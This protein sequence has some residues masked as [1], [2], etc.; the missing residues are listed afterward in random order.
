MA[1]VLAVVGVVASI[2][3]LVKSTKEIIDRLNEYREAAGELPE[4]LSHVYVEL[5]LLS[6]TLQRTGASIEN[7]AIHDTNI[8][9]P[10]IK[11]CQ[12]QIELLQPVLAKLV[13]SKDDSTKEKIRKGFSSIYRES[14][15]SR[16]TT[17]IRHYVQTLT[18]YHTV[19]SALKLGKGEANPI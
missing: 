11:G 9:E 18:Y 4:A 10:V 7:G 3:D 12:K 5:P 16:C 1:E 2:V 8:L 15:I 13:P 19:E 14:E 17:N 6:E